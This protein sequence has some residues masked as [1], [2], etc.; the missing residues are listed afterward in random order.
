MHPASYEQIKRF[1]YKYVGDRE[2]SVLEVG[3]L[4]VN[5]SFKDLFPARQYTGL[6]IIP[7]KNVDVVLEDPYKFPFEDNSFDV[8]ISGSTF[9]HIPYFWLTAQ[10]I[11]RV[12]KKG[13]WFAMTVPSRGWVA[14]KHPVDCYRFLQDSLSALAK[15]AGLTTV[16]AFEYQVGKEIPITLDCMLIARKP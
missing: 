3:S 9:E 10:E 2:V 8:V 12:L 1:V 7:G 13:G 16:E 15:Y 6:D 4:D 14:H 5:G 11:Q